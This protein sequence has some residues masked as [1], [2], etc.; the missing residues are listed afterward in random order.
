M[1]GMDDFVKFLR[2]RIDEDEAIAK[3]PTHATW[4]TAEWRFG[5][6]DG[7]SYVDL[8]TNHLDRVSSLT[9]AEMEH[10]ARHDPVRVLREVDAKR[11]ILAEH[12]EVAAG[13]ASD[14]WL[15][16]DPSRAVLRILDPVLRTL[17][18]PYADHPD[19]RNSWRP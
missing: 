19:Y 1:A 9:D 5:E 10:I 14:D 8:G 2:A 4:A 6:V 18:L 16:R 3:A 13:A 11:R 7:A 17:A 12:D 15:I